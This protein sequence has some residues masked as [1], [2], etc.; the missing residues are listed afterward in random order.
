MTQAINTESKAR[1][2][3]SR[4]ITKIKGKEKGPTIVFFSGIHGNEKAG[5]TALQETLNEINEEN[6]KGTIYGLVGNLSALKHNKRFIEKDL[7][8]L[9]TRSYLYFVS[10]RDTLT[11]EQK[12][13]KQL[14]ILLK[15]IIATEKAPLYF[16]DLHTTSGKTLPFITINDALINRKFSKQFPVPIVLGIEE[17]LQG[18]LLSY[19]NELGYVSL[20]FESGQ[21]DDIEA[22][23]NAKAFIKLALVFSNSVV[24]ESVS[25]L[26]CFNELK[27]ASNEISDFFEVI[28]LHKIKPNEPFKMI[29]GF[30]SF[31]KI[32]KG[33]LL[34]KSNNETIKAKHNGKLFMP[35]YQDI[36]EE[37]F[38]II[39]RIS[40]FVLKLSKILRNLKADSLFV[41][42]PGVSWQDRNKQTLEVDLKTAKFLAKEIFHLLGYRSQ[43]VDDKHLKLFSRER[44][45]KAKMYKNEKWY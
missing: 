16:I 19:I 24:K 6:V 22:V 2:S 3:T 27:K 32:K 28:Y 11:V 33:T 15:E 39:R 23:K 18:P 26:D 13:L 5:V 1:T 31:Q 34:A 17:Y 25:E 12:E 43:Q 40:P 29:D 44:V 20:G 42:L 35:L 45:A 41:L 30:E 9:W 21:H 37:G 4:I 36:G 7:N 38:F 14:S 10:K 8:R